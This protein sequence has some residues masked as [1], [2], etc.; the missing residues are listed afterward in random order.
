[1]FHNLCIRGPEG[2]RIVSERMERAMELGNP[3]IAAPELEFANMVREHQAMVFSLTYHFLHDR[4]AAEEVA[5][6]V[7]LE[8]HRHLAELKSPEHVVLWLRRVTVNRAID[9]VRWRRRRAETPLDAVP[10]P[11]SAPE[12]SD[13][14]LSQRLRRL[15][16]S[17]PEKA[18][19]LVL[20]R[21]QED[22]DP[23][24]IAILMKMRLNTVKSQ[25]QRALKLLREKAG[26]LEGEK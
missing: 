15:V 21:Y 6:D 10:E 4:A 17:L 20:L 14:L 19:I 5:Q 23:A 25:L 22:M 9:A 12:Q 8:L 7:F 16:A 1:M 11:G 26:S 3:A 13:V 18:R 24:E 2:G